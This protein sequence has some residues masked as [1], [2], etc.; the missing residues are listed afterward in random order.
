[1]TEYDAVLLAGGRATR[2]GGRPK[3]ALRVG[4]VRLLDRVLAA[5]AGAGR[6]IVVGP[7]QRPAVS[8][9]VVAVPYTVTCE[10]PPGGGPVAAIAAGLEQVVAPVVVVLAA[11]LPFL[12]PATVDG[13]LAELA[14]GGDVAVLLDAAGRDQ[15]LVAAWHTAA[16]RDRLTGLGEPAGQPV[17]R[18]LDGIEVARVASRAVAGQPPPWL[19][20]DTEAD[21]RRAREWT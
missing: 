20:C 1:M 9:P 16:L 6:R 15:L 14:R 13:L 7:A 3:P 8:G 17:R 10:D 21:L 4:G 18:L 12:T 11:D 5:V 19:D 2:L